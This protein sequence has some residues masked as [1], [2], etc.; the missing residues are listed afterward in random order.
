MVGDVKEEED[1]IE[2]REDMES[3]KTE[4]DDD[5]WGN[6]GAEVRVIVGH[7][8]WGEDE[9]SKGHAAEGDLNWDTWTGGELKRNSCVEGEENGSEEESVLADDEEKGEKLGIWGGNALAEE[10][11]E[12][13]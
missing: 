11:E 1:T 5:V 4:E 12:V 6:T 2:G 8:T 13:E 10:R 9:I 3:D 7:N